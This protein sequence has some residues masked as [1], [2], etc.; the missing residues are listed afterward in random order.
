MGMISR[1]TL[2]TLVVAMLS[3]TTLWA[4]QWTS[5][6]PDGGDVRSLNFDPKNPDRIYLGTSTGTLFLS[7]DGGHSWSRLAHLGGDDNV[8]GSHRHRSAE[9]RNTFMSLPGA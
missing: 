7:N 4:G 1:K 9:S 8:S 2:I 6:G 3:V 5:L